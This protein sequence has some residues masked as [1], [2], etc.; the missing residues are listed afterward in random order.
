[1][2]DLPLVEVIWVDACID[3]SHDV[4]LT[5]GGEFGGL[6]EIRDIGYLVAKTKREVILS[7]SRCY[8]DNSTRHSNTIP[9]N[10]VREI[11]YLEPKEP[12][13]GGSK[14]GRD[15]GLRP[16]SAPVEA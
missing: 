4:S 9:R 7:I 15:A 5:E 12:K 14:E 6:V 8:T 1:M 2:Q 11:I 10:W 16:L 13:D 3:T